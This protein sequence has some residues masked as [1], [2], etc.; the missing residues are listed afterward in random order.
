[1]RTP[2]IKPQPELRLPT[3]ARRVLQK[4]RAVPL[5]PSVRH[6]TQPSVKF[7]DQ[8]GSAPQ[9]HGNFF[10]T[11]DERREMA[12]TCTAATTAR[13][14]SDRTQHSFSRSRGRYWNSVFHAYRRQWPILEERAA[15]AIAS[16]QEHGLAMVVAVGRIMQGAARAMMDPR[17]ES[18]AE[19]REALAA[20]RA[21]GARFQSTYHLILLAQAL[22]ACGHCGEGLSA[23]REAASLAEETGER[24]VDAE[25]YRLEGNLLLAENNSAEAE[26]CY[27]KA[28]EMSRAQEARS[29]ELRA[30]CD[31]ARLWVEQGRRAEARDL[32]A[33]V[34]GWFTEGFETRD[35]KEAKALLEELA[36]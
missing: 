5:H 2:K 4:L 26:A 34:Y 32:L 28:L 30:A 21:T 23:L 27:L 20:Y 24:F 10:F 11:P 1:M 36:T 14:Y 12:L 29:L 3:G 35:L 31:L 9:Q 17:D 19:I 18:V 7:L 25:I 33:A 16:A 13:S 8:A 15:A 6:F 22:A